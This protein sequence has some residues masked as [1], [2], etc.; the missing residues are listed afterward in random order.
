MDSLD[1]VLRS[2]YFS[3]GGKVGAQQLYID[4]KEAIQER[5]LKLKVSLEAVR[6]WLKQQETYQTNAPNG[7]DKPWNRFQITDEP[8]SYQADAIFLDNLKSRN[9][10]YRGFLLFVEITTRRAYAF[11]FKTGSEQ[12]PPTADESLSIF[13]EFEADRMR[14]GHPIRKIS[15]DQGKEL[16]SA[17]VRQFLEQHMIKTW[18]HR[19][20]DHRANGLLNSVARYIRRLVQVDLYD[21]SSGEWVDNLQH[22]VDTW[23][24]HTPGYGSHLKVSPN[25]MA[26]DKFAQ[27]AVRHSAV[28]HNQR[29]WDKTELTNHN[30]VKRYLRRDTKAKGKWEKEGA[31]F[32]GE[33]R[34]VGRVGNSYQLE[35]DTGATLPQ[36]YRPYELRNVPHPHHFGKSQIVE[37]K[38]VQKARRE[39][40]V[41]R[42]V[43]TAVGKGHRELIV[44]EKRN[45][46]KPK[47]VEE[48]VSTE[49]QRKENGPVKATAK[50]GA[51]LRVVERVLQRKTMNGQLFFKVKWLHL[52]DAESRALDWQ[53]IGNFEEVRGG[54]TYT[55]PVIYKYMEKHNLL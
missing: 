10:G 37:E 31:T 13:K 55:N 3:P 47:P 38:P 39:A 54:I 36:T 15:G 24:R 27:Q 51:V 45:I 33:Y 30:I 23:N 26:E 20:E 6:H 29:V 46:V 43:R 1:E 7:L 34:I 40:R 8:N 52:T 18:F 21:Q 4:A 14:A 19:P 48:V 49:K 2:L 22:A 25:K 35:D 16:T 9:K 32:E 11:P 50:K 44:G 17:K 28:E 53:P 41:E 5:G 42:R 12:S